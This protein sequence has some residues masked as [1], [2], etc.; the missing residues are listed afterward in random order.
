[1]LKRISVVS[2]ILALCLALLVV[3][4]LVIQVN[5]SQVP[6]LT[7]VPSKYALWFGDPIT[8][9]G[10]LSLNQSKI[11]NGIVSLQLV[12]TANHSILYRTLP[13]GMHPTYPQNITIL[14][15]SLSNSSG[16][17]KS[18]YVKQSVNP[19]PAY[20]NMTI[21]NNGATPQ[22]ILATITMLDS[23]QGVVD[24][25]QQSFSLAAHQRYGIVGAITVPQEV[26][27]GTATIYGNI[28]TGPPEENGHP[29]AVENT[30]T[31]QVINPGQQLNSTQTCASTQPSGQF[32]TTF[33]LP[34]YQI[35]RGNYIPPRYHN[36]TI[37]PYTIYA[38]SRYVGSSV[39]TS[40]VIQMMVPDI[41]NGKTVSV[42]DLILVST[43][44]GW[45][46]TAGSVIEDVNMDGTVN[47]LDLMIVARYLGWPPTA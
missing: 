37:Y 46:G 17:P 31:F 18:S 28:F 3:Q 30:T 42:L 1:M 27:T 39:S 34:L 10:S 22:T 7:L 8:V 24:S 26:P 38:S 16:A 13:T 35:P 44:L 43:Y 9:Q 19:P 12:D 21:R 4:S 2:I 47:I 36:L 29:L 5:S 25:Y 40:K 15:L 32:V 20:F 41:K 14:W 23:A 33:N 45:T 6:V 11:S